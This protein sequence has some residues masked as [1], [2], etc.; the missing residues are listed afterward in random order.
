M[1]FSLQSFVSRIPPRY[2]AF[3][4]MLVW[5]AAILTLGLL[6][7]DAYGLDEGATRALLLNWTVVDQVAHPVVIFGMPDFRALLFIPLGIY[8][9]GSVI[10]A[11]VFTLLATFIGVWLLFDWSK[12]TQSEEVA[13]IGSGLMLIAPITLLQAD[14]IGAGPFLLMV[15][16]LTRIVDTR[17][18]AQES[19]ITGMYFTLMLLVATAVTLHPAGLAVPAALAL[20]WYAD[21]ITKKRRNQ[22]FAGFG[23]T[24]A[25]I[26][27]MR[28]GWS[29]VPW[30]QDPLSILGTALFG[31]EPLEMSGRSWEFGVPLC[32]LFLLVLVLDRKF[33]RENLLGSMLALG[34]L[35][36]L[37]ATESS[38][39]MLVTALVLYRGTVWLIKANGAIR[40]H[41]F[42]GQRGIVLV[43]L[44][45][46]STL[47]MQV[48]QAHVSRNAMGLLSAEDELIQTLSQETANDDDKLRIASQWPGRTMLATKRAALPL[49]P[50]QEDAAIFLKQTKGLTHI[51]FAHNDPANAALARNL[52]QIGGQSETIAL[53][54]GGVIVKLRTIELESLGAAPPEITTPK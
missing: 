11:K 19:A 53:Q 34:S 9:S 28:G 32:V 20:R 17:Y 15:M 22:L 3:V 54:P 23:L 39:A 33:L 49:P 26:L 52:G 45:I 10:A 8:W 42:F 21:P 12:E 51:M 44:L 24:V 29:T 4:I 38:W 13:M 43:V 50:A 41:N 14:A 2:W 6:R 46:T 36:G 35:I 37:L 5:G 40:A 18:R 47:F 48:D 7:F 25:F 31:F 27:A 30:A 1:S 16:G